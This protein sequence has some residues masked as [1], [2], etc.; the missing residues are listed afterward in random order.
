MS[1][2][3]KAILRTIPKSLLSHHQNPTLGAHTHAHGFL[4]GMGAILL[5]M[6]GHECNIVVHGWACVGNGFVHPYMQLQIGVKLLGCGKYAN[7]EVLR[8]EA[9]NCERFLFV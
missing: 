2:I 1:T 3:T 4:V 5:F 7:Q 6:G 9:N 8:A